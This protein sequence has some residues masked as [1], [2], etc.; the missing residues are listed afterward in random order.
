MADPGDGAETA[1]L[2]RL[3]AGLPIMTYV[4]RMRPD[5]GYELPFCSEQSIDVFGVPADEARRDPMSLFSRALPEDLPLLNESIAE[6]ARQLCPWETLLG[7]QHP[8]K[9]VRSVYGRS[10]PSRE[11]DGSIVW[12]GFARDAT[13]EQRMIQLFRQTESAAR[14]GGWAFDPETETLQW[15]EESFRLHDLEP[16][17][18]APDAELVLSFID[19]EDR[20]EVVRRFRQLREQGADYDL[21]YGITTPAGRRAVMRSTNRAEVRGGRVVRLYGTLQDVT[22]ERKARQALEASEARFRVLVERAGAGIWEIDASARTMF[23]NERMARMIG[24][25]PAEIQGRPFSD[26]LGPG[27]QETIDEHLRRR[28]YG[29]SSSYE[30]ALVHRD[31]HEVWVSVNGT[32]RLGPKGELLSSF[33]VMVDVTERR[34]AEAALRQAKEEAEAVARAKTEFV[35]TVSHEIRTPLNGIIGMTQLLET[36]ELDGE[37]R[38][39][40]EVVRASSETLLALVDDI[41]DFSKLEAG[42]LIVERLGF[43]PRSVLDEVAVVTRGQLMGKEVS[44]GVDVAADVP[45]RLLGD[46]VRLRQLLLNLA[47]N[48]AKFT[49]SGRI[50][51]EMSWRAGDGPSG[52]LR[53]GVADT[54]IGLDPQDVPRLFEPFTQADASTT[55]R[56]GGTGLGLAIC[57]RVVERLGGTLTADGTP[58]V[59]ARF[60]LEIPFEAA[61]GAPP[62]PF[63]ES[64]SRTVPPP[65]R[66]ASRHRRHALVAEDN[67]VNRTV[68]A[69]MLD[70]LGIR[71]TLVED[72]EAAVHAAA[73]GGF[74]LVLMDVHMPVLDGL[75]ASRRI[76]GLSGAAGSVPIVALTAH[77]FEEHRRRCLDAGMDD[78]LAK[79]IRLAT[80]EDV[81]ERLLRR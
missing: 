7:V 16:A 17:A 67:A 79:P 80:L 71:A 57:R 34:R 72:G 69:R 49:S 15:T 30:V 51:F 20:D 21:E 22:E 81:I 75:E 38:E 45:G 48:A 3:V 60:E 24:Y 61:T 54:G 6:S 12:H 59:G 26:F 18:R 36:T 27:H 29:E 58:G 11:P 62:E 37:Q 52:T 76:R 42:G 23:V 13:D 68:V 5:G 39:I 44:L 35:A 2:R 41:L 32:P 28:W 74:D 47:G 43:D 14:V 56:F 70:R 4:F 25:A 10:L 73:G 8:T 66:P 9:G 31:G 19:P 1:S 63:P 64:P 55:R 53:I 40:V 50:D 65:S 46:P 78:Y 77:A 33:A